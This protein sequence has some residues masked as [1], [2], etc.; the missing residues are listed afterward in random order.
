MDLTD[1]LSPR[2][3]RLVGTLAPRA[4]AAS[5]P[6]IDPLEA[7]IEAALSAPQEPPPPVASLPQ[8]VVDAASNATLGG[9]AVVGNALDL[10]GSMV[11]DVLTLNNPLDQLLDPFGD[12]GRVSGR[13]LLTQWG[14][15]EKND[16][17]AWELADVAGFGVEVLADPLTYL[18]GVGVA[19]KAGKLAKA[20]DATAEIAELAKLAKQGR[21]VTE[22]K[23]TLRDIIPKLNPA[24][25]TDLEIAAGAAGLKLDDVLD[26]P[27]KAGM[28]WG[29]PFTEGV[30]TSFLGLGP[31]A[32]EI[33]FGALD[34]AGDWLGGTYPAR[35]AKSLFQQRYG[36]KV[37]P[38]EQAVE[39]ARYDLQ[40]RGKTEADQIGS[41]LRRDYDEPYRQFLKE[42]GAEAEPYMVPG[43]DVDYGFGDVVRAKD[44][45]NYGRVMDVK[46]DGA[47]VHFRSPEGHE[48]DVF[49]PHDQLEM[50]FAK[51]TPEANSLMDK[52]RFGTFDRIITYAAEAVRPDGTP[53]VDGAITRV[54][55]EM[56]QGLSPNFRENIAALA[57]ELKVQ[58]DERT[59][60][61]LEWGGKAEKMGPGVG[62]STR[63]A[64][65][66]GVSDTKLSSEIV[67][68]KVLSI[69]P[70]QAMHRSEPIAYLPREV[71]HELQ[72]DPALRV[73]IDADGWE[74]GYRE[75][76][77]EVLAKYGDDL[78]RE[79]AGPPRRLS[80]RNRGFLRELYDDPKAL[81][82][83][84][85]LADG[86]WAARE[87]QDAG[88]ALD[89]EDAAKLPE[90]KAAATE[91]W[92]TLRTPAGREKRAE[93]LVQY[94]NGIEIEKAAPKAAKAAKAA[95]GVPPPPLE[96]AATTADTAIDDLIAKYEKAPDG[97]GLGQKMDFYDQWQNAIAKKVSEVEPPQGWEID[98]DRGAWSTYVTWT[99]EVADEAGD[100]YE[101]TV[102]VRISNHDSPGT[103]GR[104]PADIDIQ[105]GRR[106]G[107]AVDPTA[108]DAM[109]KLPE[110]FTAKE[111]EIAGEA[112]A[113]PPVSPAVAPNSASAA[114]LKAKRTA[115]GLPE[116]RLY[117]RTGLKDAVEGIY[118][119][120]RATQ[121][122]KAIH[123]VFLEN[124]VD[125]SDPNVISVPEA[126]RAITGPGGGSRLD[127]DRALAKFAEQVSK[128]PDELGSLYVPKTI[129]AAAN[130]LWRTVDEPQWLKAI[131]EVTDGLTQW[132][133]NNV[134]LP[135]PAFSVRNLTSGQYLNVASGEVT[136]T[137]DLAKYRK[138]FEEAWGAVDK[139]DDLLVREMEA[140]GVMGRMGFMDAELHPGTMDDSQTI[141]PKGLFSKDAALGAL[142]E[143]WADTALLPNQ[144]ADAVDWLGQRF[145]VD[146]S[147][148]ADVVRKTT[149]PIR[150]GW[151]AWMN[152]GARANH[153]VEWMNRATMFRYLRKKGWTI[154][155]AAAKVKELHF[156]YSELA[157]AERLVFR[158]LMPFYRF[159]RGMVPLAL[160]TLANHPGGV[161]A[162]TIQAA[163]AGRGQMATTPDYI[164]ETASIPL[165]TSEDGTQRYITG[166]GLP[167]EDPLS[168]LNANPIYDPGGAI[169]GGLL[170]VGSRLNP[171]VK[172][173]LEWMTGESF[174]QRGPYGGR[175]L[176]DL[177]PTIGRTLANV[178]G[179]DEPVR[180]PGSEGMEFVLANSPYSRL[181]T[182]ARQL[183][184]RRKWDYLGLPALVP[185]LSGVRI[186]DVSPA[187][188]DAILRER[189]G[190][191]AR[192]LGAERFVRTYIPEDRLAA[193]TP[194]Q[195]A[196]AEE[197]VQLWKVLA[198]RAKQ[199]KAM[200]EAG[201]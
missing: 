115:A 16:P 72:A 44:R 156:D 201:R 19:T 163:N 170:E 85:K 196:A 113:A 137:A 139:P 173:P 71:I 131:T 1:F 57:D 110:L 74:T 128:T 31:R 18:G 6:T 192:D 49:L 117:Q 89:P 91:L 48:A 21:R 61:F 69:N 3:R 199:R 59:N 23:S 189:S 164:G 121:N 169:Q 42:I 24:K 136:T 67:D 122:L 126:F 129:V 98:I 166:L 104:I 58:Q 2:T 182:T 96:K 66:A 158:R 135:F 56:G 20:A 13:D 144:A 159:T 123:Q 27:L 111:R 114:T 30:D 132:F 47:M 168:F 11:R 34:T 107:G 99:K 162:K 160:K 39:S 157:P 93:E 63:Q 167:F 141:V 92:D 198:D 51:G 43:A 94:I 185:F 78:D 197:Y 4:A 10:P 25:Q 145:G 84:L 77:Q 60:S 184:D 191:L 149:D 154:D 35:V 8:R 9:L 119:V 88:K 142:R 52:Q 118:G 101:A 172:A 125:K 190:A 80:E 83:K 171:L 120:T 109:S 76:V 180:W 65:P 177:D 181:A 124:L 33:V 130:G 73:D 37:T 195:R 127:V 87:L 32:D 53:D 12:S 186:S 112:A 134:T 150:K 174:F 179:L 188:Q 90:M 116:E 161:M 17:N 103:S 81:K 165:G 86:Y 70:E 100:T 14:V 194:E 108:S 187:A 75:A 95:P 151:G 147:R 29:L 106:D 148:G 153:I 38:P 50:A 82:E 28:N 54:L 46:P 133:K 183:T 79:M 155:A 152:T 45:N 68:P 62:Y 178:A 41:Q 175:E 5:V 193:M 7:E 146:F 22:L 143:G 176:D 55:G 40:K 97:D 102:K 105:L 15:T 138:S 200:Q 26:Q 64:T 140:G 36:G